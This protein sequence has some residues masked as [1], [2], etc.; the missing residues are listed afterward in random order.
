[1]SSWVFFSFF[2]FFCY[3]LYI[4]ALLPGRD[5]SFHIGISPVIL[6][7]VEVVM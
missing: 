7:V 6:V 5:K 3:I 2:F 4:L 1:M